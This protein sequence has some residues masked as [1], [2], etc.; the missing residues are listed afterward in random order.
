MATRAWSDTDPPEGQ[1]IGL[2]D[3]RMRDNREDGRERDLQGGHHMD[4]LT[5]VGSTTANAEGAHR[6][7]AGPTLGSVSGG[8]PHVYKSTGGDTSPDVLIEYADDG[9]DLNT[10]A[11]WRGPNVS[12]G[13]DPGHKHTAS[14]MFY[15]TGTLIAGRLKKAFR[16]PDR[17][18][19]Y[20]V[21]A[22]SLDI[23]KV[24]ATIFTRPTSGDVR[25]NVFVDKTPTDNG[26]R[27]SSGT[28]I[29]AADG[30]KPIITSAGSEFYNESTTINAQGLTLGIDDE[31][32]VEIDAG[33]APV[34]AADLT[35]QVDVEV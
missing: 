11:Q 2:G 33:P 7:G 30:D 6:V 14:I 27:N 32:F 10:D 23:V 35:V 20:P 34:G 25:V 9:A 12:S 28:T 18:S 13:T 21:Q 15:L 31:I 5:S 17:D 22:T 26:D 29:F 16:V 24:S 1:D 19:L 3:D 4:T 8:G